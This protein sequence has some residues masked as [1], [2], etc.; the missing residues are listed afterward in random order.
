MFLI[1]EDVSNCKIYS[2]V[3]FKKV[4]INNTI[5]LI[6]SLLPQSTKTKLLQWT[7]TIPS[8]TTWTTAIIII[9]NNSKIIYRYS[10]KFLLLI[11]SNQ[12]TKMIIAL[13]NLHKIIWVKIFKRILIWYRSNLHHFM[14]NCLISFIRVTM[15]RNKK[16][17]GVIIW[18][19]V[20]MK[21]SKVLDNN[22]SKS[23]KNIC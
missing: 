7:I 5:K 15:I 23:N 6:I 21:M 12:L 18:S 11:I 19:I 20:K 9:H 22:R 8:P 3:S 10:I 13:S 14:R 2:K 1:W 17:I 4:T 16:I